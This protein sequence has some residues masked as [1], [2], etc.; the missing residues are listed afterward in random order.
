MVFGTS[1][2][3]RDRM[4]QNFCWIGYRNI[5]KSRNRRVWPQNRRALFTSA[6]A[7]TVQQD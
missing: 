1:V 4:A 5:L 7:P 2:V 3:D 6:G